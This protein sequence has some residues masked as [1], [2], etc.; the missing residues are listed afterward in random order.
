MS[1]FFRGH[2][3]NLH[4]FGSNWWQ[5]KSNSLLVEWYSVHTN[6]PI[7]NQDFLQ[8]RRIAATGRFGW[9]GKLIIDTRCAGLNEPF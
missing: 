6:W 7:S 8:L 5:I 1:R 4:Q 3:S 9:R 2:L